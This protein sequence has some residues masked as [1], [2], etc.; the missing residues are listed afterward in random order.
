MHP[1]GPY[2]A[3]RDQG[4][5]S[6]PKG[7]IGPGEDPLG[8]ARREA[9]EELGFQVSGKFLP[10]QS[11]V[12]RGGKSVIAWAVEAD[13]DPATLRSNTFRL[14]WPRGSGRMGEFP[15]VDRAAWFDLT[16]ARL[17]ILAGQVALVDQLERLAARP[18]GDGGADAR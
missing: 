3:N 1:G 10:L 15:E 6:I 18:P 16:E 5:W 14:E 17:R 12:Q 8:A 4:A 2:W 11:I 9:A 13:W 7:E